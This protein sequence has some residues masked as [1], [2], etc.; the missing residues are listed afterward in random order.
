MSTTVTLIDS[1]TLNYMSNESFTDSK[2][3]PTI[4]S[5]S[6]TSPGPGDEVFQRVTN[7]RIQF[8]KLTNFA[9]N[10]RSILGKPY[11]FCPSGPSLARDPYSGLESEA[12]QH[13]QKR[14]TS[15]L[16]HIALSA[17]SR[18]QIHRCHEPLP[19]QL[20]P[21]TRVECPTPQVCQTQVFKP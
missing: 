18:R 2:T 6:E 12:P 21:L 11:P 8:L 17:Y 7:P 9:K 16:Q 3:E 10:H 1:M 14:S 5:E 13:H 15:P 4:I 19:R 20:L